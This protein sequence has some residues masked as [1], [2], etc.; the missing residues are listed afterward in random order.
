VGEVTTI[1]FE[2]YEIVDP[3]GEVVW[4][5]YAEGAV[6]A[7]GCLIAEKP[8]YVAIMLAGGSSSQLSCRKA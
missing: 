8:H 3:A 6:D 1:T 4:A 7:F 5:G 2:E